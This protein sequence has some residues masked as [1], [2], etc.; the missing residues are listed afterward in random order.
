[1]RNELSDEI[2]MFL[3]KSYVDGVLDKKRNHYDLNNEDTLEFDDG[4]GIPE[5]LSFEEYEI[6]KIFKYSKGFEKQDLDYYYH[7]KQY[8]VCELN[9]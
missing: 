9:V 4:W 7:N 3:L 5:S 8:K 2:K 1:M 6:L